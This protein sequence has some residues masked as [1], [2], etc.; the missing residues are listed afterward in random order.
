MGRYYYEPL[1]KQ[2]LLSS[3][4]SAGGTRSRHRERAGCGTWCF[5]AGHLYKERL[6]L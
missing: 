6:Q 1:A 2:H 5:L 3:K 4:S